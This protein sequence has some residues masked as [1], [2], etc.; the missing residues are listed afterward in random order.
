[1]AQRFA[2]C[3][4]V[5]GIAP[6]L[7]AVKDRVVA[8]LPIAETLI[9]VSVWRDKASH[10]HALMTAHLVSRT[11]SGATGGGGGA[12]LSSVKVGPVSK[13]FAV[14][15]SADAELGSTS[16]GEAYLL[17]K[18]GLVRTPLAINSRISQ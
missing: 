2:T 4:E 14:T 17:L 1:M 5:I 11:P 15:A 8:W 7:E 16:Y 9:T 18:R 10:A 6:E 12:K 13:S 3:A